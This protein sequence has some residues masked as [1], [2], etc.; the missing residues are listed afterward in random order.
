MKHSPRNLKRLVVLMSAML[1][2]FAVAMA[3]GVGALGAGFVL[4]GAAFAP[5]VWARS[6]GVRSSRNT[7]RFKHM[8]PNFCD[9]GQN[10]GDCS[11]SFMSSGAPPS[12]RT[13]KNRFARSMAYHGDRICTEFERATS[14]RGSPAS[15]LLP[16]VTSSSG[17]GSIMF[18]IPC[19][20]PSMANTRASPMFASTVPCNRKLID[21]GLTHYRA[22]DRDFVASL[23]AA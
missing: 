14:A 1:M 4:A 2:V 10:L 18:N 13:R 17:P 3:F 6:P 7:Y 8:A 16:F 5:Y 15:N 23:A 12:G 19:S 9:T 11:V 20:A 22:R 21:F